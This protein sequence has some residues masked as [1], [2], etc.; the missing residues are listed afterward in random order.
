MKHFFNEDPHFKI[1]ACLGSF[2]GDKARTR[3]NEILTSFHNLNTTCVC[4]CLYI[5]VYINKYIIYINV[6]TQTTPPHI[7]I[8]SA[9]TYLC[10]KLHKLMLVVLYLL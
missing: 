1:E 4:M 2:R 10:A 9:L 3:S 5:Y 7:Y 6:Y 8:S